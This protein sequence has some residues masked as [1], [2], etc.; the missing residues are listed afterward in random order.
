MATQTFHGSCHCKLLRYEADLDLAEGTGKCNCS[1]CWKDRNW[2]IG[3][4]PEQF[5]WIAGESDAGRYSFRPGSTSSHVFCKGCG[6][7]IGTTGVIEQIGGAYWSVALSTLDDLPV[8]T[9]IS[10]P[11]RHMNGR[12]DDWFHPPKEARQL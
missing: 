2:S 8:E 10:A 12:D 5:R 3:I 1:Y 11:V 4:K 7:R 9:L 6:V